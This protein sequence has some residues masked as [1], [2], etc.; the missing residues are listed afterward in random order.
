[1]EHI[2]DRPSAASLRILSQAAAGVVQ[3]AGYVIF[4]GGA[5]RTIRFYDPAAMRSADLFAT[6]LPIENRQVQLVLKNVG[7][8]TL[9]ARIVFRSAT[10][11][12]PFTD[13]PPVQLA[14]GE[15]Q[16]ID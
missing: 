5:T 1:A 10:S 13:V 16:V 12:M 14:A 2:S 8:Q 6:S 11:G 9:L 7:L 4:P 15:S 3:A